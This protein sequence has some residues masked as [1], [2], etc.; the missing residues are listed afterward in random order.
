MEWHVKAELSAEGELH[1]DGALLDGTPVDL[2]VAA[3]AGC[4]VKS[5]HMVQTARR[6]T[7]SVVIAQVTGRKADGPP[8]RVGAVRIAWSLPGV[9]PETAAKVA[10]DAKR[11]CTVTNAM[12]CDFEVVEL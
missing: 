7:P 4:F 11:I 6:E 12:S 3:I 10:R 5:C 9:D 2:L 8:N 1:L